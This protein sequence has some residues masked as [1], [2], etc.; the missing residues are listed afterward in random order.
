[1]ISSETIAIAA[2]TLIGPIAAVLITR[3]NDNRAQD[4]QRRLHVYR[5]LMAT[6]R[7]SVSEQHVGA[8]NLIEVEFHGVKPVIE[9]WSAYITHLNTPAGGTA[10]AQVI[11]WNDR[12]AELLSVLLVKIAAHLG[13]TKGEIE[14]LHGGYTPQSWATQEGRMTRI[15][16]YAVRLS[17]GRAVLPVSGQQ[18]PPRPVHFRHRRPK[19]KSPRCRDSSQR[20]WRAA[21]ARP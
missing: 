12:R 11:A 20:I 2:A 16:E 10:E 13:I 19:R 3:W 7:V 5:T 18:A 9:A 1:V 4:R 17:E 6:R 14:M 8:I 15:Q 21:P